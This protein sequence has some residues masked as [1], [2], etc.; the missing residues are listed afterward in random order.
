[1]H[2]QTH[3]G[4]ASGLPL[5]PKTRATADILQLYSFLCTGKIRNIIK[6][7]HIKARYE[8]FSVWLFDLDN[9][10]YNA[11]A[12]IFYIINRA[13]TGIQAGRLKLSE[14]AASI[15]AKIIGTDTAR[16]LPVW[17]IHHPEVDIDESFA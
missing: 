9:T 6:N 16:R 4:L 14:E 7:L 10:L 8:S 17:Q 15:C 3:F 13:M 1:M 2:G 12:G 5:K 11:E